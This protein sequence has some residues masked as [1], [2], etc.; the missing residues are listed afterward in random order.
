MQGKRAQGKRV[1]SKRLQRTK[2]RRGD[3]IPRCV[4]DKFARYITDEFIAAR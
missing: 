4:V 1:T 2:D 3:S